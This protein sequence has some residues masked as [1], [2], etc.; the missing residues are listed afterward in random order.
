MP[1]LSTAA[2]SAAVNAI[3]ALLNVSGPGKLKFRTSGAVVVATLTFSATAFP[4]TSTGVATAS[5]ITEDTN[6]AGGTMTNATL[7][8]GAGTTVM[9]CTAGLS[10]EFSMTS[11]VVA[12]GV[13][14]AVDSLTITMPVS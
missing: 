6:A 7:E 12:A 3:T 10:G 5:A 8:D 9:T 1:T 14:V 11:A 4:T 13:E 2:R